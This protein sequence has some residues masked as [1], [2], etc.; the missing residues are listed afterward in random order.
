M[1]AFLGHSSREIVIPADNM[2]DEVKR[3]LD[4]D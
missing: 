3:Q 4:L 1:E 2:A